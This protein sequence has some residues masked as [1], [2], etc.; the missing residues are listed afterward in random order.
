MIKLA[1]NE[2][3]GKG[4]LSD[5]ESQEAAVRKLARPSI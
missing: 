3:L 4:E 1:G 5:A 2:S